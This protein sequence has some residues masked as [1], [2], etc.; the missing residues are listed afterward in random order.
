MARNGKI[1]RLPRSIR[2]ELN[3]RLDDG[4][5]GA[6]I[7]EWLNSHAEVR[8]VLEECFD[9]RPINEPNLTHWRQGGFREWK[10]ARESCEW[11]HTLSDDEGQPGDESRAG[12]LSDRVSTIATVALGKLLCH[13]GMV[14]VSSNGERREFHAV[15]KAL[16]RLRREDHT[17]ARLRVDLSRYTLG[18]ECELPPPPPLSPVKPNEARLS[19]LK[20]S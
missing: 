9:G 1:A 3:R 18:N 5:P 10:H 2:D 8:P 20:P 16:S 13:P 17:A 15:L 12:P 4:E 19:R 11:A 6:P 7:L 14:S